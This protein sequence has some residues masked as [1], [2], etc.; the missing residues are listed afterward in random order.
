MRSFSYCLIEVKLPNSECHGFSFFFKLCL[1]DDFSPVRRGGADQGILNK[2]GVDV[3]TNK[4][5]SP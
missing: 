3:L 4:L 1:L 2:C 5:F